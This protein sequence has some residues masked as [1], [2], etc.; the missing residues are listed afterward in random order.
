MTAERP[1]PSSPDPGPE[2]FRGALLTVAVGDALGAPVEGF[3]TVDASYLDRLESDPGPLRTTDDTQM[4]IGIARTLAERSGFDGDHAMATLAGIFAAEPWR[5]YGSGPPEVFER[6]RH[7]TP[8][9][10][11][12]THL[13]GGSGSFGNGAAMRVAPAAVFAHPDH[14]T[15]IHTAGQTARLTHTHPEGIDGAVVQAVAVHTALSAVPADRFDPGAFIQNV[16]D[17]A[18]TEV[19]RRRLETLLKLVEAGAGRAEAVAELGNGVAARE[20]VPAALFA[21]SRHPHSLPDAVRAA[22]A[23][24]GDTDT[25]AAM[26]GALSGALLG[27]HAIPETWRKVEDAETLALLADRLR[28]VRGSGSQPA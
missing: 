3:R 15:V 12:A 20:S 8:W 5:G 21:F 25:I 14:E 28:A 6:F 26:T 23:M 27:E 10:R 22:I 4:T 24:G 18:H 11:A 7:G 9:H 19:F 16:A 2:R 17:A 13:F 1:L